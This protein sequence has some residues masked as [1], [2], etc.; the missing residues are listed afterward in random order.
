MKAKFKDFA[1][2]F[3]VS[4][5]SR[6]QKFYRDILGIEL[7][8]QSAGDEGDWL[9]ATLNNDVHLIFFEGEETIGR[10]PVIV[11]ELEEGYIDDVIEEMA[12]EGAEIVT[13]VTEAPGG[14]SADFHDP[15]GHMLSLFQTEKLP[16][17]K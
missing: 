2:V 16:R 10:S 12:K 4:D 3:N 7:E 9:I 5:I 13:P 15:D 11:F 17:R 14:W 8:R 6:T 1:V